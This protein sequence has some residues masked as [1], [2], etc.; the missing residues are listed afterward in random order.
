M[1]SIFSDRGRKFVLDVECLPDLLGVLERSVNETGEVGRTL[2]NV[3]AGF[4]LNLL[5]GQEDIQQKVRKLNNVAESLKA[6]FRACIHEHQ[7][8]GGINIC[9]LLC[10][11]FTI[12]LL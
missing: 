6:K 7:M 5:I 10:H 9:K 3:A 1:K 12:L 2:R 11:A 8:V 4:L